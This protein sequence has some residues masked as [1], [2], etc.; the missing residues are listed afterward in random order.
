ML[1]QVGQGGTPKES[2]RTRAG[3]WTQGPGGL[4]TIYQAQA[5]FQ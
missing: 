3:G 1:I 4:M 2:S 5:C